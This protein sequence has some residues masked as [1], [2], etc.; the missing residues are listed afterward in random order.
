M[1]GSFKNFIAHLI[2]G[3]EQNSDDKDCRLATAALLTRVA[4]VN[5]EMSQ[6]R[7]EKLHAVLKS[8]FGLDD[9]ATALLISDAAA[10]DR[11]AVDLYHFTR[12]LNSVLDNEGRQRIIK[13]MWQVIY[14]DE[15]MNEFESNIIWRIAD[16]LGVSSRQR[17]EL[18]QLVAADRAALNPSSLGRTLIELDKVQSKVGRDNVRFGSKA[19]ICSAPTHVRFAPEG[20]MC[21]ATTDVRFGP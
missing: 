12:R 16:L 9:L 20:N 1:F 19:D 21:S 13:M 10:A 4:T 7:Q 17:I 14:A 2:A 15:R 11:S 6:A 3:A 8:C 18:R 5:S